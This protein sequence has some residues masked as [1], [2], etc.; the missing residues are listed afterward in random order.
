M[1]AMTLR[2]AGVLF[3]TAVAAWVQMGAGPVRID[4]PVPGQVIDVD[5]KAPIEGAAV[6]LQRQVEPPDATL[7]GDPPGDEDSRAQWRWSSA[8]Q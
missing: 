2:R 8:Q 3:T 4:T 5:T 6:R 7:E 1:H